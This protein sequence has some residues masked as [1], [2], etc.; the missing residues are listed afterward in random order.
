VRAGQAIAPTEN[1]VNAILYADCAIRYHF[2]LFRNL[3]GQMPNS[4]LNAR[5]KSGVAAWPHLNAI[6]FIEMLGSL[7]KRSAV[8]SRAKRTMRANGTPVSERK[9]CAKRD[10][11]RPTLA[12]ASVVVRCLLKFISSNLIA[13]V[14]L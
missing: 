2:V 6:S 3:E 12:A 13:A 11:L 10:R 7:S 4:C 1:R 5:V 14:I 8:E 9:R